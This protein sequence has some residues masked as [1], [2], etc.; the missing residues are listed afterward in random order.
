MH[1]TQEWTALK[2][3]FAI[4]LEQVT[5]G[6]K[7]NFNSRFKWITIWG[8]IKVT[9]EKAK[10]KCTLSKSPYMVSGLFFLLYLVFKC[11]RT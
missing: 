11:P 4:V 9:V 6:S 2:I 8:K 1:R 10:I 5:T 3:S 7:F